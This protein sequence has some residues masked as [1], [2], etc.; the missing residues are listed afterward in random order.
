MT[1]KEALK[2]EN[3][4]E[5]CKYGDDC[6]DSDKNVPFAKHTICWKYKDEETNNE[7]NK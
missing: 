7:S 3:L 5:F 6:S 1:N 4:C 2:R